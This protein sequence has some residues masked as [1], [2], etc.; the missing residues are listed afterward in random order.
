MLTPQYP[1]K[2]QCNKAITE[3]DWRCL[4]NV[5]MYATNDT[6]FNIVRGLYLALRQRRRC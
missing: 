1:R 6:S 4:Y 2:L 3:L 5:T